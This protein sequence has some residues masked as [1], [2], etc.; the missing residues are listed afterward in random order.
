MPLVINSH[1]PTHIH[2]HKQTNKQ[3][4]ADRSNY[5]KLDVSAKGRH[6]PGLKT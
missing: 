1:T 3:T 6:T 5:K 2:T 4:F